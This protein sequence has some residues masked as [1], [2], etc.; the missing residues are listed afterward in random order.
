MNFKCKLCKCSTD[1]RNVNKIENG[2]YLYENLTT[3]YAETVIIN[4]K[5]DK[6]SDLSYSIE[7]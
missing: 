7:K 5:N 2:K 3:G 1:T 6:I 4:F